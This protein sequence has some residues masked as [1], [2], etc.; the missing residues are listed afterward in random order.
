[1]PQP[2][3]I[4][5]I[6][7]GRYDRQSGQGSHLLYAQTKSSDSTTGM[8]P[9]CSTSYIRFEEGESPT[10]TGGGVRGELGEV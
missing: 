8:H 5:H 9:K 2:L 7:R 10:G 4:I 1:M 6:V 3:L